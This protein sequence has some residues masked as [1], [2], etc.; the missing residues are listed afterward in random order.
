[1]QLPNRNTLPTTVSIHPSQAR[2]D[3]DN[4]HHDHLHA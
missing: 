1:M 2:T 3:N 4:A